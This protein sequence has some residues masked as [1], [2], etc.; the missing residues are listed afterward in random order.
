MPT[1]SFLGRAVS[2]TGAIVWGEAGGTVAGLSVTKTLSV[3]ALANGSARMG[4]SQDLGADWHQ[5][6]LILLLAETGTAPTA[7]NA[8]YAYMAESLDGTIWPGKVTGSDAAYPTTVVDN[9]KQLGSP[10]SALI[11]TADTNTILRQAPRLYCP[12]TRYIAPVFYNTLGQAIRTQ[13]TASANGSGI[14]LVPAKSYL[15]DTEP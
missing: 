15:S 10:V 13:G 1:T 2:T 4:A 12:A 7:G 5:D 6:W 11:A 8:V 9:L 3:N 14:V